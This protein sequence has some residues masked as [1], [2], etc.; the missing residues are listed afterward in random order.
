SD[1]RSNV[2]AYA[3]IPLRTANGNVLGA[4]CAFDE[5]PHDWSKRDIDVLTALS[6]AVMSEIQRRIAERSAH[7]AQLRLIAERTLA[8]AVQQ[9]MPVGVVVAEV[10]SGRLVSVNAQMTEIF[11]AAFKPAADLKSYEWT[12]FHEDGRLYS[13]LEWPIARTVITHQ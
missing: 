12:G 11:C 1:R 4:F 2:R 3:G 9:Q 8:H 10:P 5:R 7:D 6:V 13:A